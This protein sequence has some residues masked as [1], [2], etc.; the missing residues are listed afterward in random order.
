MEKPMTTL[1]EA[2]SYRA[3]WERAAELQR[4][5][6]TQVTRIPGGRGYQ[7]SYMTHEEY[8]EAIK[9]D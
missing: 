4:K 3:A 2:Y 9:D 8:R 5:Y 7:V 6:V 1:P